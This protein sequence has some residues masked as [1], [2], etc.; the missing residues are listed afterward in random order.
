MPLNR[1][2]GAAIAAFIAATAVLTFT[3]SIMVLGILKVSS[4]L[5]AAYAIA[6][7]VFVL[8][9]LPALIFYT[10]LEDITDCDSC[11]REEKP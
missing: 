5:N 2:V 8:Q 7:G 4:D 11:Q 9:S 1:R 3:V 10:A 6:A